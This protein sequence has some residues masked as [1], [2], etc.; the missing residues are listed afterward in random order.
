MRKTVKFR[1]IENLEP[2]SRP[3]GAVKAAGAYP[4]RAT[5]RWAGNLA[6]SFIST[7]KANAPRK[8]LFPKVILVSRVG[9]N[10]IPFVAAHI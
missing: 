10:G 8:I 7:C 5:G 2:F 4:L 3:L 6:G 9:S 1:R